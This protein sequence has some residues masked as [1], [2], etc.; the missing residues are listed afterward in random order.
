MRKKLCTALLALCALA[1]LPGSA[2]ASVLV[3]HSG[4][5]WGNPLPQGMSISAID[6]SG[7]R[8]YAAGAFG[9][10]LR[11]DD[12]GATWSGVTTGIVNDLGTVDAVDANT[13]IIGGGCSARRSDDGGQT[14]KRLPF[15]P[16]EISCPA[17]IQAISFPSTSNGFLLLQDG[18][19]L[20][21]A[22]GGT[23]FSRRTAIPGTLAAGT[24]G[25]NAEDVFFTSPTVGFAATH[26]PG[27]GKLYRTVDG[28]FTWNPVA[29]GAFHSIW[30]ADANTGYA[31]GDGNLLQATIDG[32]GTWNPRPLTGAS[33]S[34]LTSIRCVGLTCLLSTA[35]G[36]RLIRTTDGGLTGTDVSPSSHKVFAAAFASPT[37][38]VAAGEN[39]TTVVSNDAGAT[40]SPVG[41]GI[42]GPFN[43]LV[44]TSASVAFAPGGHG[45]LAKTVDAG[46]SWS[47]VGV[48]TSGSVVDVSFPDP[49]NGF[50]LDDSGTLLKSANGGG[51]WSILNTGTTAQANGLLA[52]DGNRVLLFEP[53]GIRRSSDGGASFTAVAGKAVSRAALDAGDVVP[54]G[55]FAYGTRSLLFS[56]D[57]GRTWGAVK[58]PSKAL[59]RAVDFVTSKRGYVLDGDGRVWTT[60][61]RGGHWTQLV[62]TGTLAAF[63]LAF[64]S[65]NRGYLLIDNFGTRHAGYLLR[66]PDGGR[67]WHPQ[68]VSNVPLAGGGI[69]T[70]NGATDYL[71]DTAGRLFATTSGGD[72]GA[73]SSL[74][75]TTKKKTVRKRS[76]ITVNGKLAPA[77]GGEQVVVSARAQGH[78]WVHKVVQVASD[79]TFTT[80]WKLTRFTIF[81]AQWAGDADHAGAGSKVLAVVVK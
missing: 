29:T 49:N 63:D 36:T 48:A 45:S 54:G 78:G 47:D 9:T 23:S 8:G 39:G 74:K 68:L 50:A 42:T 27:T 75:L 7:A 32:G 31:V 40:F 4:W 35:E 67:T 43:R 61:N 66:T 77:A 33:P 59:L 62:G 22:D 6:F 52:L 56:K 12:Q 3:G 25:A 51:S 38:V 53:R 5:Y 13:V 70:S 44:A 73:P 46:Q 69:A 64:A 30:F 57:G 1:A 34:T 18:T 58:P 24:T 37:R 17:G 65:P 55:L 11:T 60:A 10:L 21:T 79:G 15:T 26:A 19:L 14:F 2:G 76:T 72:L 41:G 71:M 81:V 80:S 16:S 20:A 28:G